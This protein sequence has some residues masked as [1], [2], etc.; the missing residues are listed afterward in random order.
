MTIKIYFPLSAVSIFCA[1]CIGN[2]E[3]LKKTKKKM[4]FVSDQSFQTKHEHF[5]F[6]CSCVCV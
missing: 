3:M 1:V 4:L 5:V 6:V 2:I